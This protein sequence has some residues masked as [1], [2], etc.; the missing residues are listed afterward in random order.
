MTMYFLLTFVVQNVS[1]VVVKFIDR[2]NILKPL[3]LFKICATFELKL[4]QRSRGQNATWFTSE[5]S[6]ILINKPIC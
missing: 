5:I 1:K 2:K 4:S 3:I 6:L